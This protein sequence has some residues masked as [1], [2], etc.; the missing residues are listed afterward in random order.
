MRAKSI[1]EASNF[2][3]KKD[4]HSALGMKAPNREDI[5][6]IKEK[7]GMDANYYIDALEQ[8]AD[9][10]LY[11]MSIQKVSDKV[12]N[13]LDEVWTNESWGNNPEAIEMWGKFS[14]DQDALY[15]LKEE[16]VELAVEIRNSIPIIADWANIMT[17]TSEELD[18]N[19]HHP[20]WFDGV[21]RFIEKHKDEIDDGDF[22]EAFIDTATYLT[23]T[24]GTGDPNK[25]NIVPTYTYKKVGGQWEVRDRR[26]ELYRRQS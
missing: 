7:M 1:N 8:L 25:Y 4:I 10:E 15:D 22:H 21:D 24:P 26:G 18:F 14:D 3:R 16:I 23:S 2:E 6:W 5:K 19:S 17:H 20:G 13:E 9:Q 11:P 12:F